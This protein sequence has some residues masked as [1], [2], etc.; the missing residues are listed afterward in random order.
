MLILLSSVQQWWQLKAKSVKFT[1]VASGRETCG[2]GQCISFIFFA[3]QQS[4]CMW[5]LKPPI[6][7]PSTGKKLQFKAGLK[8]PYM[9]LRFVAKV[10]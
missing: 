6:T 3:S 8:R 7:L 2:Y 1:S 5:A 9:P 4:S 10:S